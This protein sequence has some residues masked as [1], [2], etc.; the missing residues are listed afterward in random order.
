[1]P[2]G[3]T[4]DS[5]APEQI[6]RIEILRAPTAETGARAV[7]GTIN[8]ITRGGYTKRI[9]DVRV[10]VALENGRLQPGVSWTRNDTVGPFIYNWSLSAFRQ[11]RAS[12]STTTTVDRT[13]ADDVLT[14]EPRDT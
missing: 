9:N 4:L 7:A 13:L 3:F 5:L 1:M 10:G 14:L 2:A 11:N 12:D 8:I 6:E